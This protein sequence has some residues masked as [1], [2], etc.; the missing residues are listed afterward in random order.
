MGVAPGEGEF[1]M[2]APQAFG[3]NIDNK[4]LDFRVEAL[5]SG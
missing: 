5:S 3:G 1:G 2:L 4:L